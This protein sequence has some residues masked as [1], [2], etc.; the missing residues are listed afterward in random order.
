METQSFLH[1][2]LVYLAAGIVIGPWGLGFITDAATVLH[3]AELGVVLLLFLVG[4]ELNASRVWQLR[5]SIFGLGGAQVAVTI[6]AVAGIAVAAGIPLN[7]G[8]IAGM[9]FAMS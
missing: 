1:Q 5:R 3:F 4:L 9:G 2:A 7:V 8:V 6:A